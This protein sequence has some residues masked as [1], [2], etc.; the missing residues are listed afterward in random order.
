MTRILQIVWYILIGYSGAVS[1][2]LLSEIITRDD[3]KKEQ[4]VLTGKVFDSVNGE[5]LSYVNV[6]IIGTVL[7]DVT[8][9]NGQFTI[10]RVPPGMYRVR[11]SF[12]GYDTQ[13]L[14]NVSI[15]PNQHTELRIELS[16]SP[17]RSEDIVITA[18][19]KE[20]TAVLAPASVG[21]ISAE[22]MHR[23]N[24][25]TFDQAI[26]TAPSVQITRSSSS[27]VQAVSIRGSSE[28]AGAGVGNRV[29]L[30][31]DG[32]PALSP[33]SG[34]ALWNLVPTN[35]VERIEVVK[36]AYSSLY[37][38]S[39][40]GGVVNVITK[41][42]LGKPYTKIHTEYGFY[43]KAP[44]YTGYDAFGDFN[45]IEVS[46]QQ[47]V[48]NFS[49]LFDLGRKSNDGHKEN[50]AFNMY[51]VY[52]KLMQNFSNNRN[53]QW[54]A[55]FNLIDNGY[56][57]TWRSF[58]Q[59]YNVG[60]AKKDN[61]Q[62]RYEISSDLYY[63]AIP[64]VSVKY[65]TRFYYYQ[66]YC[67][68][69]F[70]NDPDNPSNINETIGKETIRT[71]RV[72]NVT[73][74][75]YYWGS[76]HYLIAGADVQA[77]FID[78]RP[79]DVLY[80]KHK[81][82][83]LAGYIQD[84]IKLHSK[85]ITTL[86]MRYD[87]NTIVNGYSEGNFSPKISMVYSIT[88][89]WSVRTLFAQAFRNPSIA[90]RYIQYEQGGGIS[91]RQSPNLRSEKLFASFEL[92]TKF[93]ITEY[94]HYDISFFWNEYKNLIAYVQV[95]NQGLLYEVQ[96]LARARMRG[97]ELNTQ[98][99]CK[100]YYTATIGY[101]YLDARDVSKNAGQNDVGY[102]RGNHNL[103]YKIKHSFNFTSDVTYGAMAFNVNGR[104]NSA[105]KEVSIYPG[106]EPGAYFIINSKFSWKFMAHHSV[107]LGVNNITNKQY[108][109]IE[110]YRMPGRNFMAGMIL[111]FE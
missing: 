26:E 81:A 42:P 102:A 56:P 33:E 16:E 82:S 101:T 5:P 52:T 75:D 109:E 70:W 63:Y 11:A 108:E 61:E 21:V 74:L 90:E 13:T 68:Y 15:V 7:G 60:D 23:K 1:Q 93:K 53:M 84:E 19:R 59:P 106:S 67:E 36:G 46:H 54:S 37:G 105:I 12:I 6:T 88:P 18:S 77:D 28:V 89:D 44:K 71:R 22:D 95:P 91:F 96:N 87:Y 69:T 62:K 38:S 83:N 31:I 66:N 64:S 80:G 17:I 29:L 8:D 35:S 9:E 76:N 45:T 14:D 103:P 65:S 92:G 86:G 43:N 78:A 110:R 20:Q 111:N 97:V 4:G 99:L 10:I 98:I 51:S 50:T 104:Y 94:T 40:M 41:K 30:L 49:Y 79:A 47:K 58:L 73:Q 34:G 72:G 27:N 57:G 2:T 39:A 55:N 107:Y 25:A 85:L 32:R 3:D 48:G 100:R 24:I